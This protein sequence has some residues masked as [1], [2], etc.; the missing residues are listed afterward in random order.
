MC[1]P[2]R[3]QNESLLCRLQWRVL[4]RTAPY[5]F[6]VLLFFGAPTCLNYAKKTNARATKNPLCISVMLCTLRQK[7]NL[8]RLSLTMQPVVTGFRLVADVR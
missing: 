2:I 7:K 3:R 8:P 1:S 4:L 5:I 6:C